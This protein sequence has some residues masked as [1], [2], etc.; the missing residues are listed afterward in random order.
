M[1]ELLFYTVILVGIYL[2]IFKLDKEKEKISCQDILDY[3][4]INSEG[5]IEISDL[6]FRLVIEVEP[7]NESL[8]SFKERQGLWLGFRN[9]V[10]TI[11]IPFSL[12]IETRFLDLREYLNNIKHCSEQKD[13]LLRDYGTELAHW[14]DKK[15][16]NKQNRD[17]RCYIILSLDTVA[18]GGERGIKTGNPLVNN[19]ISGLSIINRTRTDEKELRKVAMDELRIISDVIRSAL[20]GMDIVSRQ[21]NKEEV[22]DMIYST[23][24]RDLAPYCRISDADR[25]HMFSL[26]MTTQTPEDFLEGIQ[27]VFD[28]E[29]KEIS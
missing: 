3:K 17:R 15:T 5:I 23:F 10:Q 7:V 4:D 22:L 2:L 14:L 13:S 25:E 21:L 6:K 16:E 1:T 19:I 24:N 18:R 29:E 8:K 26:F 28:E 27:Y 12:K 9:L 20:E 11:N